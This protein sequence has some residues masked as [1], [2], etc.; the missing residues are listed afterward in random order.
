MDGRKMVEGSVVKCN[1]F[2]QLLE[3][4]AHNLLEL[5]RSACGDGSNSGSDESL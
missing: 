3:A 1:S 2:F 4:G 5:E